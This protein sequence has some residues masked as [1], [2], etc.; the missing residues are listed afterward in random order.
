MV[1][2]VEDNPINQRVARWNL[3]QLGCEVLV[4]SDGASALERLSAD[5]FDRVLMDC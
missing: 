3:E 1:L 4:A 5:Q 2:L